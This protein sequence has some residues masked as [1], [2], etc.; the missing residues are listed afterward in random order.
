MILSTEELRHVFE[1]TLKPFGHPDPTGF[2]ARVLMTSGGDPDYI[3]PEGDVGFMPVDPQVAADVTGNGE[4][5]TLQGNLA[6]TI[7]IDLKL[8][9][10]YQ[11]ISAMIIA[12]HFGAES[13]SLSG[14]DGY[15]EEEAE[16]LELIQTSRQEAVDLIYPR[17]AT[18]EDVVDLIKSTFSGKDVSKKNLA[19]FEALLEQ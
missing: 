6:A 14:P 16:F 18:V 13:V 11:N 7:A 8:Y 15:G 5:S 1:G 17:L 2:M 3:S 9:D 4:V 10:Q 12:F 19:M